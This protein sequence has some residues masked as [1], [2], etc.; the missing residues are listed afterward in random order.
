MRGDLLRFRLDLVERLDDRGDADRARARAVRAHAELHL[1][2]ISVHDAD[3]LERNA[4]PF[5]DN[6]REGRLV[7]LPVLVTAGEDFDRA[8][9]IDPHLR[10][11]PQ[12][13]PTTERADRLARRDAASLDIGR[14][15]NAAQ[16][17]MA[18][19]LAFALGQAGIVS[20]LQGL[21]ERGVVI[22]G[23]IDH[24]HRCLMRERL[25]EILLAQI[26]RIHAHL[27]RPDLD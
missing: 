26:G 4:E 27:P 1:V 16:L 10:R 21:F 6:L 19:R 25:D 20:K 14:E 15:S 13:D 7:P 23:V 17:V 8:G 11:L 9:R 2:G 24:D 5:A 3:V 22:A 18:N 12:P